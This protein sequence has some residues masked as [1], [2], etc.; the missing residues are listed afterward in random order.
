MLGAI[1]SAAAIIFTGY[2][3]VGIAGEHAGVLWG[4]VA[5]VVCSAR[6]LCIQGCHVAPASTNCPLARRAPLIN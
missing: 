4:L 6:L 3:A 2:M 5:C 1:L